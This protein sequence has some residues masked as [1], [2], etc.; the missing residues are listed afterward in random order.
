MVPGLAPRASP[1]GRWRTG[2]GDGAAAVSSPVRAGEL[3]PCV[4]HRLARQLLIGSVREQF[5]V[6]REPLPGSF[7]EDV[8]DLQLSGIAGERA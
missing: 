7:M 2:A 5:L 3:R 8:A 6:T 1:R 4:G